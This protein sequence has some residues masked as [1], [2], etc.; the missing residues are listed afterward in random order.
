MI[1]DNH[2]FDNHR[3]IFER[4]GDTLALRY[5]MITDFDKHW[6]DLDDKAHYTISML[7]RGMNKS[8]LAEDTPTIF[9]NINKTT[10]A[11]E[12]CWEG[13]VRGFQVGRDNK[14]RETIDFHFQLDK[15]TACPVRYVG[16]L[17]GWHIDETATS[18]APKQELDAKTAPPFF[19]TISI[20]RDA[21]EFEGLCFKLLKLTGIHEIH[22]HQ[23]QSG[24]SDGFFK[25]GSLAVIYDATLRG[26]FEG[27]KGV[28][29]ENYCS[30]LT[31]GSL[32]YDGGHI[33][34]ADCQKNVWVITRGKTRRI[35][36][37]DSITVKEVSVADL[38]QIY[39][40]RI[41]K[42]LNEDELVNALVSLG[43]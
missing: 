14:G 16:Y 4:V 23:E 34:V 28:Q 22:T 32:G 26:E 24:K 7:R 21:E 27:K 20:T 12:A 13:K 1:L 29:I 19:S 37:V 15:E 39:Q 38:I 9:I 30:Q 2:R 41:D 5:I 6:S 43:R 3:F 11:V 8:K 10:K 36:K 35:T 33:R 31:S 40:T 42:N 17:A 25:I 18:E